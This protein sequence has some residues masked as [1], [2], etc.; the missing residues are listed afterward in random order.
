M[1]GKTKE[2][3]RI[4]LEAT[5]ELLAVT[6]ATDC[7]DREERRRSRKQMSRSSD[8]VR[9]QGMPKHPDTG[10]AN[11]GFDQYFLKFRPRQQGFLDSDLFNPLCWFLYSVILHGLCSFAQ[12]LRRDFCGLAAA[13][14]ALVPSCSKLTHLEHIT[15]VFRPDVL[16]RG[17][18]LLVH[19]ESWHGPRKRFLFMV[20]NRD[21]EKNSF[22]LWWLSSDDSSYLHM[23]RFY[24]HEYATP[25]QHCF[26]FIIMI[27]DCKIRQQ[28]LAERE[29]LFL[30][31]IDMKKQ[32]N[33]SS[34]C[35]PCASEPTHNSLGV[36]ECDYCKAWVNIQSEH[37]NFP[38]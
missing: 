36:S 17:V 21:Q 16:A 1:W 37:S 24:G 35:S 38:L 2:Q 11:C 6:E 14:S 3:T 23:C 28:A 29:I 13:L 9:G 20:K 12:S 32:K 22:L 30:G 5:E 8:E 31:L 7:G 19:E 4:E 33:Y 18:F 27:S 26:I 25:P 15:A 34:T 10:N